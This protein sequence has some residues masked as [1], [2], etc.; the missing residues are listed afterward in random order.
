MEIV[1]DPTGKSARCHALDSGSPGGLWVCKL[2]RNIWGTP[3]DACLRPRAVQAIPSGSRSPSTKSSGQFRGA[4][5]KRFRA[6]S[7]SLGK[8]F[9]AFLGSTPGPSWVA[10]LGDPWGGFWVFL[11]SS[12]KQFWKQS[13]A[14]RCSRQC[15]KIRED[16]PWPVR[17]EG[18]Q[19]M[20]TWLVTRL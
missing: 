12:S 5:P 10:V 20:S 6:V 2:S 4:S 19:T 11:G 9:R 1:V 8:H 18:S 15:W 13:Y 3:L 14:L 7:G 17:I 16:E